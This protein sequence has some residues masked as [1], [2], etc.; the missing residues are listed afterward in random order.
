MILAIVLILMVVGTVLFHIFSPWY[1]TP[2][3]SNWG[4]IDD[5]ISFTFWVTG[6]VFVAVNLFMAYCVVRYR[7]RPGHT[8]EYEPENAKLEAW[9]VGLTTLGVISLLAPGLLVWADFVTV[10]KAAIE[11]EAIGQQ[12][13]WSYR[14]PGQD[15]KF[16]TVDNRL[17]TDANPFGMNPEDP[18]GQDDVLIANPGVHLPLDQPVKVLLRSKDVL[19]DFAVAEFRVKM[20]L[21]PGMITY[22]W[23]TP[24]KVGKYELLCEELC[25]LAHHAMRGHVIVDEQVDFDSWLAGQPTYS[26]T[27]AQ[28]PGDSL[29]G[30]QAY[31]ICAT[32]HGVQGAGN[33]ALNAPKLSGQGAWNLKRQ[34]EHYK[35]GV[36]GTHENDAFGKLMAPMAATLV[37]GAAINNVVAY[38]QTLPDEPVAATVHGDV[39]SGEKIYET[40]AY[41]HGAD[42]KGIQ[43]TNAPRLA[44]I[45]DWYLKTQLNNFRQGIRG[46]H[47]LD[48]H[49]PQMALMAQMLSTDKQVDDLVTYINT[50]Q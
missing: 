39:A 42:G 22:L 17:V 44:G 18:Y 15:G 4:A 29:A 34:L 36:R 7:K 11:V 25:G 38:I 35:N 10:P 33:L 13:H 50:L 48:L 16:G 45:N 19:H 8:A 49:G 40:C 26:Q 30:Q 27:L 32:C 2:L 28:L 3:A 41:C 14:F 12:W 21:V 37:D 31:A 1:L 6:A 46:R 23:F 9:L 43:A 47:P 24:T 20:D 5:T